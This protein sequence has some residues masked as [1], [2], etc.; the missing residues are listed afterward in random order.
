MNVLEECMRR[1]HDGFGCFYLE[2]VGGSSHTF[3]IN[4]AEARVRGVPVSIAPADK[5]FE[6]GVEDG[7]DRGQVGGV[8]ALEKLAKPLLMLIRRLSVCLVARLLALSRWLSGWDDLR[9]DRGGGVVHGGH[10]AVV[11]G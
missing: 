3:D 9:G 10:V 1:S 4:T 7:L 11:Q 5:S 8:V 2:N 6:N